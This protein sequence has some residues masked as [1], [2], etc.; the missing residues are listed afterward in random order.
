MMTISNFQEIH[1]A[2]LIGLGGCFL[3]FTVI[4]IVYFIANKNKE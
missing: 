3:I 1:I 4:C 2:G